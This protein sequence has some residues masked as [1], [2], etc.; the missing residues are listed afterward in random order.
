[1]LPDS[2][3]DRFGL[4][5]KFAQPQAEFLQKAL[6]FQKQSLRELQG[7]NECPIMPGSEIPKEWLRICSSLQAKL[8]QDETQVSGVRPL[9]VRAYKTWMKLS[10]ALSSIKGHDHLST[11]CVR[12]LLGP[13]FMHRFGPFVDS[14]YLQEL[15]RLFDRETGA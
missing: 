10:Q 11:Q 1:V 3:L 15:L 12:T 8:T 2:Q 5:L 7:S 6:S 9:G 13:V 14:G 4:C